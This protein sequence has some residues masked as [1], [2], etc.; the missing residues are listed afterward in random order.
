MM[1]TVVEKICTDQR[2]LIFRGDIAT[3]I[4][5]SNLGGSE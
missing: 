3:A 1:I 2:S 5:N 4:Q